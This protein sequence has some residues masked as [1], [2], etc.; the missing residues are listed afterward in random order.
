MSAMRVVIPA[1]QAEAVLPDCLNGAIRAGFEPHEITVIDDGSTDGTSEMARAAGVHL[2]TG[3]RRGAAAARNAGAR[4]AIEAGAEILV[5]V[6]AD[7]IM[8]GDGKIFLIIY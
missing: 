4:A 6:D 2:L 8:P 1:Y 5:F 7:V 3:P